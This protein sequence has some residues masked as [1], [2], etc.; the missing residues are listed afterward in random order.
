MHCGLTMK[1]SSLKRHVEGHTAST[2][3]RC[4]F[5]PDCTYVSSRRDKVGNH[6]V[7]THFD[8]LQTTV[9]ESTLSL[10]L[11]VL[12]QA[13]TDLMSLC[14]PEPASVSNLR[15]EPGRESAS[16]STL[17]GPGWEPDSTSTLRTGR[18]PESVSTPRPQPGRTEPPRLPIPPRSTQPP[19]PA[20]PLGLSELPGVPEPARKPGNTAPGSP[21]PAGNPAT[22]NRG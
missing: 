15:P 4:F 8:Q 5:H 13:L 17:P 9:G 20:Q 11:A 1:K 7:T 2:Q 21:T 3:F 19:G 12:R 18:E 10:Y 22:A 14:I 6:L 16:A